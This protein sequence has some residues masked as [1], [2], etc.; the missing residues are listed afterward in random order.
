MVLEKEYGDLAK[1]TYSLLRMFNDHIVQPLLTVSPSK[2]YTIKEAMVFSSPNDIRLKCFQEIASWL[3][4][5][6]Y[7][8]AKSIP[9]NNYDTCNKYEAHDKNNVNNNVIKINDYIYDESINYFINPEE[10]E[11]K[12]AEPKNEPKH[13]KKRTA[14]RKRLIGGPSEE[15]FLTLSHTLRSF[16]DLITY[17]LD[18]KG[19]KYVL[20]GRVNNDPIEMRFSLNRYLSGKS[21][22]IR[23]LY[24]FT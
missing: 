10:E 21:F 9:E 7:P 13:E 12:T 6:W 16:S 4:D 18:K 15:T 3:Q 2:G 1:E 8:L 11:N 20:C 17:L 22:S 14:G 23:C 19:F 5:D 24:F